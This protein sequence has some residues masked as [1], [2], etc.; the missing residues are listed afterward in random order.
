MSEREYKIVAIHLKKNKQTK[1]KTKETHKKVMT[2][3]DY[4]N[5]YN[6]IKYQ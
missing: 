5:N 2:A 4:H 6:N 1:N 3:Y